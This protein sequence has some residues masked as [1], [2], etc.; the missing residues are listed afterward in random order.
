MLLCNSLHNTEIKFTK[1][2]KHLS[3]EFVISLLTLPPTQTRLWNDG[4]YCITKDVDRSHFDLNRV[5]FPYWETTVRI[6]LGGTRCLRGWGRTVVA[7]WLRCS[8]TNRWFNS[9][10]CHW[11]FSF[12]NPS[13]RTMAL[14][15]TQPL[16]EMSTRT[17]S[18]G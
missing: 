10:W 7:Q 16:V 5:I 13:D 4:K 2:L 11:N 15:S 18:W 1:L 14:G 9:R 3:I 8:T 12:H 17:I 6:Y